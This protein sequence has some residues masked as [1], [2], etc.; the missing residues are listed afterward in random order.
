[1]ARKWLNFGIVSKLKPLIVTKLIL[2]HKHA[3]THHHQSSQAKWNT[4]QNVRAAFLK[5]NFKRN[6]TC[7]PSHHSLAG[8]NQKTWIFMHHLTCFHSVRVSFRI[9]SLKIYAV[10]WDNC[11]HCLVHVTWHHFSTQFILKLICK[12]FV[13]YDH[14][15]EETFTLP[16]IAIHFIYLPFW[17]L[18]IVFFS[19]CT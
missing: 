8:Y 10:F 17:L 19:S 2:R 1:M 6:E 3:P 4:E 12:W 14:T 15:N 9:F 16:L 13:S 11:K 7:A 18:T 5:W